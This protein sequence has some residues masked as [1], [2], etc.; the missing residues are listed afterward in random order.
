MSLD[1]DTPFALY[2][3]HL[4]LILRL[5]NLVQEGSRRLLSDSRRSIDRVAAA[6]RSETRRIQEAR[7]WQ[8]LQAA[9]TTF[10]ADALARQA[11]D[12]HRFAEHAVASQLEFAG[13]LGEAL[14]EWQRA[15][16]GILRANLRTGA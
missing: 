15:T 10:A 11:E 5:G 3:T 12:F 2:Q 7:D 14:A 6:Q 1:P 8:D 9:S 13:H 4:E 16:T